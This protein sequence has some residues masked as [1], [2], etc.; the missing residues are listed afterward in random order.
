MTSKQD[1]TK[2]AHAAPCSLFVGIT[3]RWRDEGSI[4]KGRQADDLTSALSD[5][6]LEL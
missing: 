5:L 2:P 6:T 3:F 4:I 1:E